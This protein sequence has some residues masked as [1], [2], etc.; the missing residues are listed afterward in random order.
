MDKTIEKI[1]KRILEGRGINPKSIKEDDMSLHYKIER[2]GGYTKILNSIGISNKE[3]IDKYG[4]T[5]NINRGTLS[6]DEIKER[7]F[8]LKGIGDLSTSGMRRGHFEDNKLEESIKK[9]YGSVNNALDY[10]NLKRDTKRVTKD[11]LIKQLKIYEESGVEL[12]YSNMIQYDSALV[13]NVINKFNQSYN[14]FLSDN[15]F[16]YNPKRVPYSKKGI[17]N[18]L[19]KIFDKE[20]T[21]KHAIIKE[22]DP[23]ILYYSE[24]HY[25]S[26]AEFLDDMGYDSNEYTDKES[27]KYQG[28]VFEKI[29]KEILTA[30]GYNFR[31]NKYY[32]LD[33]RPDFQLDNNIW[34]DSKLSS[35]T[36]SIDS[37]IS[38]YM[39][40]CDK[41]YIVYLR[42]KP[43]TKWTSNKDFY[44]NVEFIKVSSLYNQLKKINR[45]DLINDC[46]ELLI[47]IK[48]INEGVTTERWSPNISGED[49]VTV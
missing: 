4:F 24:Q 31:Y 32:N 23:S 47:N 29:V 40:Y 16:K 27:L 36:A 19:M 44:K 38:N 11:E 22:H 48:N 34:A 49:E 17:Q 1:K 45:E 35:W 12:T 42:G 13:H 14:Q 33:I 7:L 21:V 2:N 3:M 43:L 20:G 18:R 9:I 6:K 37:T 28:F 41:L 15:G 30:L 10:Y 26:F 39:P 25:N 46:Q 8:Y 5:G